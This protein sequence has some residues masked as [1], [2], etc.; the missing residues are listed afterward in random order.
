[1]VTC[2]SMLV[3]CWS[4]ETGGFPKNDKESVRAYTLPRHF[5]KWFSKQFVRIHSPLVIRKSSKIHF[6]FHLWSKS[7]AGNNQ[8]DKQT[9][10]TSVSLWKRGL[11]SITHNWKALI[12]TQSKPAFLSIY[13]FCTCT[14]RER[15]NSS[16]NIRIIW[17]IPKT[18]F[19]QLKRKK[20]SE[21]GKEN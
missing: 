3:H 13:T 7:L 19:S 14:L 9:N 16:F 6:T 10:W 18:K 15:I 2:E 21:I 20:P 12:N 17:V 11:V 1:M 5:Y 4:K 8:T